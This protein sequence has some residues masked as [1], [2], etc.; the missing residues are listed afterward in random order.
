[1]NNLENISVDGE[2][3][4]TKLLQTIFN[5]LDEQERNQLRRIAHADGGSVLSALGAMIVEGQAY[6]QSST[7]KFMLV[8]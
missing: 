4:G 1:M 2:A 7:P 8:H 3:L 5:Q 6:A